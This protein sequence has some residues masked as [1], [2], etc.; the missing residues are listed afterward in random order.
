MKKITTL[1]YEHYVLQHTKY[2]CYT[3]Y[4]WNKNHIGC[5]MV[6]CACFWCGR[7][8]VRAPFGSNQRLQDWYLLSKNKETTHNQNNVSE[9]SDIS[10]LF[11]SFLC[12][13]LSTIACIFVF[14][15]LAMKLSVPLYS[16]WLL[17]WHLQTFFL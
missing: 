14:F 7:L 8:W 1:T 4:Q 11:F 3:I 17:L 13:V 15:L 5:V 10:T 2:L 16:F 6:R 9:C 12:S